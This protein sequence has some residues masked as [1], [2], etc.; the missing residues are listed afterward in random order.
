MRP[1][2]TSDRRG[3]LTPSPAH[4]PRTRYRSVVADS[5]R[6]D[7]LALRAGDIIIS[8]PIKCGTTWVQMICALL[9]FQ[10]RT[11][12]AGLDRL[13]PWLDMLT[14]PIDEVVSDLKAQRHRRFI[15]SH[16]PLD[17]LP[18]DERVTY[19]CVGRDP[20]DVALSFDSQMTNANVEA[21]LAARERAVGL[22]DLAELMPAS[23]PP[24]AAS[25]HE[26]FWQWVDAPASPGLAATVRH[27]ATFWHARTRPNVV[28]LH[29][30]ELK[31]DL[32]GEM[33]RLAARLEIEVR[34]DRW[35]SLVAAAGFDAMRRRADEI[36][37]NAHEAL[38]RDNARFFNKGMSG[39]WKDLLAAADLR[40]YQ[41]AIAKLAPPELVT[42]LHRGPIL[43]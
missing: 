18:F 39:Q 42:W 16:T 7:A 22:D 26:R 33:R 15:K 38:W 28:L 19:V 8:A 43:G 9:I 31:A 3:P 2:K 41:D 17:G 30:D 27:L 29:Y 25:V 11:F 40:R 1:R 37:P 12:P 10:R 36:V 32:A 20:R 4:P 5:A 23:P 14:R 21:F 34:A 13:S 6:W 35:P 24:R